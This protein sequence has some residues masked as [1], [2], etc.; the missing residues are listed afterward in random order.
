MLIV[1]LDAKPQS[2]RLRF[3]TLVSSVL[4]IST[5]NTNGPNIYELASGLR[6]AHN[7]E[8]EALIL[9]HLRSCQVR[10]LCTLV[11]SGF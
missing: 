4:N 2:L 5:P 10:I 1:L 7:Q 3:A 11:F 6:Y 8:R 9:E